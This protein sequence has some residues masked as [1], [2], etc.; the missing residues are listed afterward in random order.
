MT[1]SIIGLGLIG[2]SLALDLK[3]RG[4]AEHIIGVDNNVQHAHIALQKG[5]VDEIAPLQAAVSQ[6]DMV[7]LA[8]PVNVAIRLLPEVMNHIQAHTVVTDMGSTKGAIVAAI[9][10]HPNRPQFVAAHP[11]AGTEYS[12]PNAAVYNL[13]DHKVAIICNREQSHPEAIEQVETLF[14]TLQMRVIYMDAEAHDMHAAYVSHIS[15][16]SSFVLATTVLEKEKS[17]STIFNLA[18]GGFE[19][20][21]RLAKSSPQMWSQIFEQNSHHVLEVMDTYIKNLQNWKQLIETKQFTQLETTMKD[22]NTIRKIL[23]TPP[24]ERMEKVKMVS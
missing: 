8:I 15:H 20:T 13:F 22:A 10:Q 5:I 16:I 1:I 6:A 12:G 23:D 21:V 19:S 2:G 7:I 18:S 4:F 11:M 17:V 9:A 14:N 24:V 3:T